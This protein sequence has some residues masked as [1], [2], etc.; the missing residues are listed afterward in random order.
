VLSISN[1]VIDVC[2]GGSTLGAAIDIKGMLWTWG[3]NVA[4]ELGLGDNDPKVHPYPVMA[5]KKKQ[6]SHVACGGQFI[7]A[8][9][10]NLKKEI[11]ALKL[12]KS[13][14]HRRN[15]EQLNSNSGS[16]A[17]G[18]QKGSS[19]SLERTKTVPAMV[20]RSNKKRNRSFHKLIKNKENFASYSKS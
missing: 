16:G 12:Q 3:S 19:Q 1:S 11:P 14:R 4:G 17:F 2:L 8:L 6:V 18:V 7:V 9:G 5:L 13:R 20:T 15:E 10:S